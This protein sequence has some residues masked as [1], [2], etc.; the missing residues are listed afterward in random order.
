[1]TER[2]DV[3]TYFVYGEPP[4][5]LD[6][7]FFHVETV[8]ERRSVHFG[9]VSPHK[10]PQMGQITYWFKGGGTYRIEDR[11]WNFLAPTVSFVPSSVVHAFDVEE[12]SDAVVISISDDQ[13]RS[14]AATVDLP[15]DAPCLVGGSSGDPAWIR[16][17]RL[18][19]MVIDEYLGTTSTSPRLL[20]GLTGV[21]LSQIAR[22]GG[23]SDIIE[24]APSK[25]LAASLRRAIDLHYREDWTVARYVTLLATTRHLLDKAAEEIFGQSVKEMLM[26]RRLLEAKRLLMF[27]IRSVED[28][29]REIGFDDP[30]YFSRFFRKR[31][32]ISPAAWRQGRIAP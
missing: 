3:P 27:T 8:M 24:A 7:G 18:S 32:G 12:H 5:T 29:A 13:L 16:L 10:H 31:T 2:H 17:D 1:M 20:A 19:E 25:R 9:H 28:I 11:T 21:M 30:A 22:V 15:L 14:L 6:V 4:R 26:E 23:G